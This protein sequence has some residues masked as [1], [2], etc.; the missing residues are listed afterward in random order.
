MKE[1]FRAK[2]MAKHHRRLKNSSKL[3]LVS[4]MDIFTILVFFLLVSSGE[5]ELLQT[6][7]TITL[8]DSI[9]EQRP[10]ENLVIRVNLES[11]IVAD[12]IV[13]QSSDVMASDEQIIDA[14]SA[15]LRALIAETP[16]TELEQKKGRSVTILGDK[17]VPYELLRRVMDTCAAN[18]YRAVS[19][20]VN[21]IESDDGGGT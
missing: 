5:H 10:S 12:K 13:A 11:I 1:S 7:S 15:Q 18:D 4:L 9:S 3:N 16:L 19:F 6:D 21:K 2:R 17:S 20:G 14:L 8:P